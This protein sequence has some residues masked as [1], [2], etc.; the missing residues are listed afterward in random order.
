M[1]RN[2]AADGE[3]TRPSAGSFLAAYGEFSAAADIA[4][5]T[6]FMGIP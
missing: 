2:M 3:I 1:G 4:P 6:R 5:H